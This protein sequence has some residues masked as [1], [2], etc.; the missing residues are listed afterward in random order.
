METKSQPKETKMTVVKDEN[1]EEIMK[2][3]RASL[4]LLNSK[5]NR[6]YRYDSLKSLSLFTYL[7]NRGIRF[8]DVEKGINLKYIQWGNIPSVRDYL[9]PDTLFNRS[10]FFLY[11]KES[12][13]IHSNR[14]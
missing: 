10:N 2:L 13:E 7:Y 1:F 9:R 6:S 4:D 5:T 12:D 11:L 8:E 14:A 3:A